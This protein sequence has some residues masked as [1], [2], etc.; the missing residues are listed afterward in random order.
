MDCNCRVDVPRNLLLR[1]HA[2]LSA[3]TS[4]LWIHIAS[5]SN[6]H[7]WQMLL[8]VCIGQPHDRHNPGSSYD[9]DESIEERGT[10]RHFETVAWERGKNSK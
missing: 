1:L 3:S 10:R 5:G 4:S 9:D 7:K 2:T 8:V 6:D